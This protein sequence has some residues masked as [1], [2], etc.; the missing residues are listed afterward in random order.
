MYLAGR[1]APFYNVFR[2]ETYSNAVLIRKTLSNFGGMYGV[3]VINNIAL[4]A[5]G[6]AGLASPANRK[7]KRC[8]K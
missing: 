1:G 7:G 5:P 4:G 3:P 8:G 6:L 2:L